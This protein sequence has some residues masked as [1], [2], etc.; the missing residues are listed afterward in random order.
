M[1]TQQIHRQTCR[2]PEMDL[3]VEL[4]PWKPH[5][6]TMGEPSL[7][8]HSRIISTMNCSC[9]HLIIFSEPL[10][11]MYVL[12]DHFSSLFLQLHA[13]KQ[14]TIQNICNA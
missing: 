10:D 4:K 8:A 12:D 9:D 5:T 14:L 1:L 7:G 6:P 13:S 3:A 2:K 11:K